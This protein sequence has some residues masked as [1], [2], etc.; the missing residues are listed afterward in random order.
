[1]GA[2]YLSDAE[3]M[4]LVSSRHIPAYNLEA[5]MET[6][7]R[8]VAIRRMMLTSKLPRPS[9]LSCLPYKNYDYSK[10]HAITPSAGPESLD[11]SCRFLSY[12]ALKS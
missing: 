5:V 12:A 10:V 6:P 8:G 3:V 4:L 11:G 2:R 7:E 9:A 1:M